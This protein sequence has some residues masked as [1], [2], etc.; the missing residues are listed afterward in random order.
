MNAALDSLDVPRLSVE[1]SAAGL[2]AFRGLLRLHGVN[3]A[4]NLLFDSI[5]LSESPFAD[6]FEYLVPA[7]EDC[8]VFSKH[9]Y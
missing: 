3:F 7:I 9:F 2:L 4:S 8:L 6:H 1:H 5:D